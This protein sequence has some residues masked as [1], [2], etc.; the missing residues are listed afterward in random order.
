M[1]LMQAVK[2]LNGRQYRNEC[3]SDLHRRMHK[4]GI[5]AVFGGSDDLIYFAGAANDEL[6]ARNG[7]EFFFT[8]EGL[9]GNDCDRDCPHYE[10]AKRAAVP[11]R[12]IWN[13]NG[14]SW[15]YDTAIPHLKFVIMEDDDTY[16][17][18]IVFYLKDVPSKS[19]APD[20]TAPDSLI[21]EARG[22]ISKHG[23]NDFD[24]VLAKIVALVMAEERERFKSI[25]E[26]EE[27]FSGEPPQHVIDAM[28]AAG[29]VLNARAAVKTTKE[30]ILRRI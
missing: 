21:E 6:G 3:S 5:V 29:P 13:D 18:G 26:T 14:F 16:C 23:L 8:T 4:A 28:I 2:E 9:L 25:V 30:S 7:S 17:Q 20:I 10:R 27:E 22:F 12:A 11:V 24:P 15:R 1:D 19:K